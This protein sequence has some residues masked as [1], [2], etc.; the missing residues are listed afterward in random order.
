MASFDFIVGDSIA[1][2]T[3]IAA[4][5]KRSG[6]YGVKS[7]DDKG[8][9][10]VGAPPKE[11]LEFLKEI[12]DS[13]LKDK[14][15]I[16]SS[17]ISNGPDALEKVK[18]QLKYLQGLN[19]KVYIIGVSN[20]PT[21]AGGKSKFPKLVGMNE[22]LTEVAKEYNFV[23]LGGFKP[24]SDNIHPSSYQNYYK[25]V[26]VPK[27]AQP[28]PTSTTQTVQMSG[29]VTANSLTPSGLSPS[30][31]SPSGLTPSP[32]VPPPPPIKGTFVFNTEKPKILS[33][34][35]LGELTITEVQLGAEDFFYF[36]DDT[37]IANEIVDDEYSEGAFTGSEE[38]I[39]FDV[40]EGRRL[41]QGQE[42][43]ATLNTDDPKVAN[44]TEGDNG[45]PQEA[46]SET[47][48]TEARGK[49]KKML[50][51]AKGTLGY[52]EKSNPKLGPEGKDTKFGQY[53]G[54]NGHHYCGMFVMWCAEHAGMKMSNRDKPPY[55]GAIPNSI[56]CPAGVKIFQ[57]KDC[58]VSNGNNKAER[59]ASTIKPEP[60]D[61][62]FFSWDFNQKADHVGMVVKDNGNGTVKCYEGNTMP[63]KGGANQ[64][65]S[66]CWERDREKA[67]ILGYGK[68]ALWD[69]TNLEEFKGP[70]GRAAKSA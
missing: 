50:E 63:G 18:E 55:V 1:A 68:L 46:P 12:G 40:E 39:A 54:M 37:G 62:V 2:G 36:G 23:F 11:V 5:L 48:S 14:I 32:P 35:A 27:L 67:T 44:K 28:W 16:L 53:F 64:K 6:S 31:M 8:I 3:A 59:G 69:P 57:S 42:I 41:S 13:K 45:N 15:V 29:N 21:N 58:W 10:K 43:L 47:I 7:S 61:I 60:G 34:T 9:S 25:D 70:V 49:I 52:T 66:G 4:G 20:D 51:V 38:D 65:G 33:S 56:A 30:G 19:C 26:V 22:K 24:S 17:G